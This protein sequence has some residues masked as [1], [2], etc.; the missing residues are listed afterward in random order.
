[1]KV[2]VTGCAGVIGCLVVDTLQKKRNNRFSTKLHSQKILLIV[3]IIPK[4]VV[5]GVENCERN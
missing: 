2:I 4:L 1:M 3:L 5:F